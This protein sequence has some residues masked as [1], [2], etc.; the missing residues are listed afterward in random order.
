[1][2]NFS[3]RLAL[4][5]LA[6]CSWVAA[7]AAAD[8][9]AQQPPVPV[10]QAAPGNALRSV[11]SGPPPGAEAPAFDPYHATGPQRGRT[12]CP[13]CTYGNIA[14]VRIWTGPEGLNEA[15]TV[16]AWVESLIQAQGKDHLKG[17]VVYM[18]GPTA[19]K[20]DTARLLERTA[21]QAALS[22]VW[23]TLVPGK[24]DAATSRAYHINPAA[25]VRTT[26]IV[27]V[28]RQVVQTFVNL[29]AE[30]VDRQRLEQAVRQ[31][32]A[33][34]KPTVKDITVTLCGPTEPGE[35]LVFYG[36][37]LDYQGQPLAKASIIAYH[38]DQQGLY[39]PKNSKTRVPRIR[40]VAVTDDGGWFRFATIRPGP[41][42]DGTEPAHVHLEI[43]APAH[44]LRYV[45]FW[46][47]GDPLITDRRRKEAAQSPETVIV[48]PAR[49]SDGAW[50]FRHDIRLEGN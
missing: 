30:P 12:A 6:A 46:F 19:G 17:Y 32:A 48:K 3:P 44:R 39:N 38:A 43:T 21:R 4:V 25:D 2:W 26:V 27:Y 41:Y 45:T 36:R 23:M 33:A 40:G 50:M 7:T 16:A 31:A 24:K 28:N 47:E 10:V 22:N 37:I 34:E 49:N 18:T 11:Q 29:S 14:G 5:V 13:L 9:P 8:R 35:R 20:E 1:M 42:P 15:L